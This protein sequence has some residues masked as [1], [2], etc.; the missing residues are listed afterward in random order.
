VPFVRSGSRYGENQPTALDVGPRSSPKDEANSGIAW[1]DICNA[2]LIANAKAPVTRIYSGAWSD[3]AMFGTRS[4][5]GAPEVPLKL[6]IGNSIVG[7][8]NKSGLV[9]YGSVT[10]DRFVESGNKGYYV[11]EPLHVLTR[12]SA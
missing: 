5:K 7:E 10:A 3:K 4:F 6:R 11:D 9:I 1:T 8:L 12:T 2:D